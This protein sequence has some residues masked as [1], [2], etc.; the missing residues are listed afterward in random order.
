MYLRV[1]RCYKALMQNPL[2]LDSLSPASGKSQD[3]DRIPDA[4][5]TVRFLSKQM[6]QEWF[7]CARGCVNYSLYVIYIQ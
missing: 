5:E 1:L 3:L 6:I 2:S 4:S 7:P